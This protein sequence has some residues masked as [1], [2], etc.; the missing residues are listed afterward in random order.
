MTDA[1]ARTLFRLFVSRRQLLEWV[2][3]AQAKISVR[4][5]LRGF[6]RWMAAASRLR[7]SPPPSSSRVAAAAR[8]RSPRRS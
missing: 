6:Y 8:G 5:D 3:A 1:I 7:P 2:T 4:L